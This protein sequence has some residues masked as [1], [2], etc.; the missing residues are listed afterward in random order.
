MLTVG[1]FF[2]KGEFCYLGS[3]RVSRTFVR[4]WCNSGLPVYRPDVYTDG[5]NRIEMRDARDKL[6]RTLPFPLNTVY[7]AQEKP[8]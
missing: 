2:R 3:R 7:V 1:D 5:G 4:E 8:C 6:I